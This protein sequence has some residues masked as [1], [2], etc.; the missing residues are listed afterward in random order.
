MQPRWLR[1][2]LVSSFLL[3]AVSVFAHPANIP[4]ARAKVQPDGS[5][6]LSVRFDLLAFILEETPTAVADPPMN[7]LLEG[8]RFKL[9]ERLNESKERFAREMGVGDG[10]SNGTLEITD[11]PTANGVHDYVDTGVQPRLPVMMMVTLKGHLP[12]GGRKVAFRFPEVLGTVVLTTEFPYREPVSEPVEPGSASALQT[13]PTQAEVLALQTSM[14]SQRQSPANAIPKVYTEADAKQE[15]QVRYN[16]WSKAYM[17]NDVDTLTSILTP[18]YTIKT[19]KGALI[20]RSEYD[21]MLNI[22][23]EKHSDTTRYSTELLRITLR[24]GVAAIYSRETTTNPQKNEKTGKMESLTYQHDYIDVW[25]NT[26]GKWLL[27]S[28]V[29]LKEQPLTSPP[30]K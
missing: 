23:K 26:G 21:V 30:K 8:P 6:E 7:A 5:F 25:V 20:A 9:Q 13:V 1:S 10:S 4:V 15:I 19:A 18:D 12:A 28:T 29:T 2:L 27:R 24:E 17:A 22:R 16:E 11:Y 3:L 14:L